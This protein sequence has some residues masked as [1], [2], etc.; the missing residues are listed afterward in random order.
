MVYD[1]RDRLV[2]TQDGNQRSAHQWLITFY[3]AMNRPVETGIYTSSVT[4]ASLQ[5]LMDGTTGSF[6]DVTY[7]IPAPSDMAVNS[8]SGN[9]PATSYRPQQHR[10]SARVY[11][12]E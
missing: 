8:R 5:T 7:S 11:Q 9:T 3:D 10:L 12:W 4:R 6:A 1:N 2:F